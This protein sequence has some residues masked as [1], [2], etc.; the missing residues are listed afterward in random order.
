MLN[1]V[2]VMRS[3]QRDALDPNV[4]YKYIYIFDYASIEV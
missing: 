3:A 1:T 4:Y 2:V